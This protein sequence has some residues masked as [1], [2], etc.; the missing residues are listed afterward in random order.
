MRPEGID[1]TNA[2][3]GCGGPTVTTTTTSTTTTTLPWVLIE[4]TSLTLREPPAG[5]ARRT[6]A[7]KS[8]TR[9]AAELNRIVPPVPGSNG[10]PRTSGGTL[11]VYNAAGNGQAVT[12]ALPAI[13]WKALGT[14]SSKPHGYRFTATGVDAAIRSVTVKGDAIALKGG[15]PGWTYSLASPP[16]VEIAV[17]L[18]L[19]A[20]R[21]WCAAALARMSGSPPSSAPNDRAD[22]FVGQPH[23]PLPGA[24]PPVP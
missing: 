16:Q 9:R 10:D 13:G 11:V 1:E 8:S 12:V 2:P 15:G 19:G 7:F 6:V 4:S 14:P 18:G 17:R 21:P 23:S 22:R 5:P 24:C 3:F 20:N